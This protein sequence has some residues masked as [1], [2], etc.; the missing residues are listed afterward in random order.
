MDAIK[1]LNFLVEIGEGAAEVREQEGDAL[2]RRAS[3]GDVEA[4]YQLALRY[5]TGVWGVSQNNKEV[6]RWFRNAAGRGHVPA[7][8]SLA[9]IY[10]K[11]LI[12][13]PPDPK[14]AERGRARAH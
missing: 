7:M 12:G 11:G 3:T 8:Q 10:E 9:H 13:V 6:M 4:Q 14:E 5:E 1:L 2:R